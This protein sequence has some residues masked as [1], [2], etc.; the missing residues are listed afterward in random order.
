VQD[1]SSLIFELRDAFDGKH[2]NIGRALGRSFPLK[3]L[4]PA[5]KFEQVI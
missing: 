4:Y 2:R 3:G 1:E 5:I